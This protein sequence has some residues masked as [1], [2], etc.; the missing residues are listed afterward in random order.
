MVRRRV[1]AAYAAVVLMAGLAVGIAPGSAAAA[2]ERPNGKPIST[3][4]VGVVPPVKAGVSK[5]VRD[6]PRVKANNKSRGLTTDSAAAQ[7]ST[8]GTADPILQ[9]SEAPVN[10]DLKPTLTPFAGQNGGGPPDTV[11]DVGP[12]HYV[13]MVN[14]TFQIWNKDGTSPPNGGPFAI[15]SLTG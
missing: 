8:S 11:G 7:P 10:D 2:P 9:A 15:N 1:G 14:T 3:K 13:Q 6:L 5:P 12:N 4:H